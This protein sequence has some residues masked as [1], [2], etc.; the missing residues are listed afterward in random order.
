MKYGT[1]N[2]DKRMNKTNSKNKLEKKYA[3]TLDN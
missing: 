3:P 2:T 1:I